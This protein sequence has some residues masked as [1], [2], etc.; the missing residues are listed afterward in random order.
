LPVNA[1]A[2]V[3]AG[4]LLAC[5]EAMAQ[6]PILARSELVDEVTTAMLGQQRCDRWRNT[7]AVNGSRADPLPLVPRCL[8]LAA[9][10]LEGHEPVHVVDG[11]SRVRLCRRVHPDALHQERQRAATVA[12]LGRHLRGDILLR[13]LSDPVQRE[14]QSEGK[15]ID[16]DCVERA[17]RGLDV[18]FDL[19]VKHCCEDSN[20]LEIPDSSRAFST[21]R[22]RAAQLR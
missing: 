4:V 8:L 17:N 5:L 10:F 16:P 6:E 19:K 20:C 2:V 22:Q 11:G 21:P 1:R 3:V 7:H 14:A 12:I 18:S 13:G 15:L 9:L